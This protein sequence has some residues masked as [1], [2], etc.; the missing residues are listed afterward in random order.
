MPGLA[1]GITHLQKN[2]KAKP[3]YS[4]SRQRKN[5]QGDKALITKAATV[6]TLNTK[7][8]QHTLPMSSK[9]PLVLNMIRTIYSLISFLVLSAL[10]SFCALAQSPTE[11][12][13]QSARSQ[14]G[15]TIDYDGSYHVLPYPGGD[16]PLRQGVCTDVVI[17]AYR[18]LE[19]DLQKL[20]HEDMRAHFE[21]Y[22]SRKIWGLTHPDSNID[23]RRVPNLQKFF[24]R[25]G[26]AF[27]ISGSEA[28]RP[29]DLLTWE[30]PGALPHI[31]IVSDRKALDGSQYLIIHNIGR[32]TKEEEVLG[33]F[34]LTGHYRYA[35]WPD[36]H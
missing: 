26:K 2:V 10:P 35:P 17:R 12:L 34:K 25:Q 20:V 24:E 18:A 14:I 3:R 23:H 32:G 31:G 29:G 4:K 8:F 30:L 13:L 15:R 9:T 19:I 11:K 5:T 22:P 27:G 28:L 1:P 33:M 36:R 16:V 6:S 7:A 21:L